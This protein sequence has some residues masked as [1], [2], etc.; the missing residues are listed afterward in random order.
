VSLL[1]SQG[2][3]LTMGDFLGNWGTASQMSGCPHA[4][5]HQIVAADEG[6][7]LIPATNQ[8]SNVFVFDSR[9]PTYFAP[10]GVKC[11][12]S[13]KITSSFAVTTW[14]RVGDGHT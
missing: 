13:K 1:R 6:S 5:A 3:R 4:A 7:L 2:V 10:A 14:Q 9:S 12:P 8:K 11:V